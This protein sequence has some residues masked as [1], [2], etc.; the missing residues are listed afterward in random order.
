MN[1]RLLLF[2]TLIASLLVHANGTYAQIRIMPLGNSIT[3]GVSGSSDDTGYRRALYL[4]LTAAGY[5]INFV[6]SQATGILTDFDR[7]HEGHSGWRADQIRDNIS[8]WLTTYPAD[9][10]LL[11]IGTN[12]ISQGNTI[13]STVSEVNQILDRIDAR[14]TA[15]V[16]FLARIINRTDGYIAATRDYNAA[17]QVLANTRI[18]NG[19]LIIVVD[20]EAALSYPSDLADAVHPNDSGYLKMAQC[21][22]AS[23]SEYLHPVPTLS[24]IVPTTK[25]VGDAPFSLTVDGTN[26]MNGV[27]TV[28]LNN[29]PRPT[30]YVS[31]TQLTATISALDLETAGSRSI[32]VVNAPPGGGTSSAVTL[33]VNKGPT[34][35]VLNGS[36][37]PSHSGEMVTFTATVTPSVATG[38][39]EFF[40]GTVSLGT[41][42]LNDGS[43]TLLAG[44]LP[45]VHTV[46]AAYGGNAN[47]LASEGTASQTV[48]PVIGAF[49]GAN[50]SIDPSGNVY[51]SFG[52]SQSFS[53]VPNEG[54]HTV[55]VLV[56]ALSQGAISSYTFTDVT[57]NHTIE[58]SFAII[59][60]M[61][62]VTTGGNGTIVPAGPTVWVNH[63]ESQ[64]FT[65]IPGAGY[66]VATLTIDGTRVNPALAHTFSGITS[67][68]TI[69]ATFA[70]D[71]YD[72]SGPTEYNLDVDGNGAT[73]MTVNIVSKPAGGAT[74]SAI[75]FVTPPA[76]APALPPDALPV[77]LDITSTLTDHAFA[78]TV[79]L[80][81]DDVEGFG[82]SS[83]LAFYNEI[84]LSW[85][86]VNGTYLASDPVFNGHPSFTFQTDHFG[87]F[88]FF[89]PAVTPTYL[90]GSNAPTVQAAATIH[91]NNSWR[92]VGPVY[93]GADDWSF[94]GNQSVSVYLVP[95]VGSQFGSSDITLQWDATQMAL[96]NVDFG[97]SGSPNGLFGTGQGYTTTASIT[98]PYGTGKVR[99]EGS[100]GDNDNFTTIAGDYI[101]KVNFTL[102]KPGHTPVSIIGAVFRRLGMTPESACV[103]PI[104]AEIKTYLGDIVSS[105]DA[106][107]G[108][109]KVDFEDLTSW[110]YSYWAGV[111]GY[112]G[113]APYKVKYDFGPTADNF[114]FSLPQPDGKIEFEDLLVFSMAYGQSA[115]RYLPK[116][117]EELTEPLEIFLGQS[118]VEGSEVL[119]PVILGGGVTDVRGLSLELTGQ[120]TSFLGVE[121]GE[122]LKACEDPTPL[123]HRVDGRSIYLDLAVMGL[124]APPLDR[125]GEV[126]ILRFEGSP[127][128]QLSAFEGRDSR[129]RSLEVKKVRSGGEAHPTEYVLMQNYPNPFNPTTLIR[130]GLPQK[131]WVTL[132]V[133]NTLGQAVAELVAGEM[134]AGYHEVRFD[135][136]GL[137]SGVY[138]CRFRARSMDSATERDSKSGAGNHSD[139]KKLLLVR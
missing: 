113:G 86:P 73:D 107:S 21:W 53:I 27:S 83:V 81:L 5:S 52:G 69:D 17:L 94:S 26:F 62:T 80:D 18:A 22:F 46:K 72:I 49:A 1:R 79:R 13:S 43:A 12:D 98:T 66:H 77:Y 78:S 135:A 127:G 85:V 51:V 119:I 67:N 121:K 70:L 123:L 47:Y 122:L 130:Y 93:G 28:N 88:A 15:T 101:A 14:S 112:Q 95:E 37:N 97:S 71:S 75:S 137:S 125:P 115:A 96:V 29:S 102:L 45:G 42:P 32:T 2:V 117:S 76:G 89:A 38:S 90:Y 100:R 116:L 48:N 133:Y 10:I 139:T 8:G 23:L 56:D 126:A 68:H 108:D 110:S 6:G 132:V 34:F 33:T 120:F 25:V 16:V 54:F 4:S 87:A 106:S 35:T 64:L 36:P 104:Q 50:G 136:T 58:A 19:D 65:M 111:P 3:Q 109:G 11:H 31:S 61:I 84:T 55:D 41:G 30:T 63:G 74:L 39:V 82:P 103:I 131:S 118:R 60:Y 134:E 92:P 129:N 124:S 91:P 7:D 24:S 138:F 44:L 40:D 128:I 9:I 114:I 20:Q 99:I 59:A 105:N 57:D